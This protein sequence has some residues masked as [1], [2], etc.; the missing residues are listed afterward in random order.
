MA[1]EI[2]IQIQNKLALEKRYINVYHK[3][4]GSAYIISHN[5]SIALPLKVNAEEDSLY[6]S[7]VHGQGNS[8]EICV[9]N[10]P[11]WIDFEFASPGY[12]N[13]LH[14]SNRT[15]LK[16]SSQLPNW[17][18]KIAWSASSPGSP[19]SDY[20]IFAD[21]LMLDEFHLQFNG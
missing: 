17:Q 5:S 10:L 16:I 9:V 4:T 15:F 3:A 21:A 12:I 20:V 1:K 7:L 18:L 14:S 11:S 2:N 8:Q 19:R 6:I 13:V